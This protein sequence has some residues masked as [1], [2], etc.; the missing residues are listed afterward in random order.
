MAVWVF[1]E[2]SGSMAVVGFFF[3]IFLFSFLRVFLRAFAVKGYDFFFS[4]PSGRPGRSTTQDELHDRLFTS[5]FPARPRSCRA[6][7]GIWSP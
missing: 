4:V 7:T 5:R 2:S 1:S 3:S 6:D